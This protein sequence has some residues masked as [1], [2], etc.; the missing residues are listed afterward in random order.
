M[1]NA[2]NK[3]TD[4]QFASKRVKVGLNKFDNRK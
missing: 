4:K 3:F 2:Q 1:I